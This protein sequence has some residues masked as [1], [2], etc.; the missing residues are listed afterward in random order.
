MNFGR[1]GHGRL[2]ERFFTPVRQLAFPNVGSSFPGS[3]T[4]KRCCAYLERVGGIYRVR[5]R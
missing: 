5:L 4:H 3:V 2:L 1:D